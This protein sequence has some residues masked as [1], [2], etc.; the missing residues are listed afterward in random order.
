MNYT[1]CP[2]LLEA[3]ERLRNGEQ[4]M[5]KWIPA[6]PLMA[7]AI[8]P[9][10]VFAALGALASPTF[11]Q[12][13]TDPVLWNLVN[14]SMAELDPSKFPDISQSR[15]NLDQQI[16]NFDRYLESSPSQGPLWK[17]FLKWNDLQKELA[18]PTP[19][20]EALNDLEKRFRQNYAGLE[21]S[22]FVGLRDALSKYVQDSR[23]ARDPN[24][25]MQILKNRLSKLSERMQLPDMERDPKAI[26]DLA[27]LVAYMKQANQSPEFVSS[28]LSRYSQ[29]NIRAIVSDDFLR[30]S[31]ARPVDQANPVSEVILGTTI[32]GQSILCGNVSPV[33]LENPNQA[34]LRLLMNAD[35]ASV[36]KGYNRGVVLNTTGSADV[37]ACETLSLGD[38]GLMALGDTG[39]DAQLSTVIQSIEHRL[40]IVRKIAAKQAAKKKPQADAIG[41]ARM[42]NRIR[43]QFHQ[44]LTEQLSEANRKLS[45]AMESPLISR[46]GIS[47][48]QR[49]SWSNPEQLGLRWKV[50]SGT[51][52]A[53]DMP[54]PFPIDDCG[55]TLQIHESVVG[56]LLDPVLAGRI[57]RSDEIDAYAAQFGDAAK[58]IPRKE[59]DGP[60]AITLNNFQPVETVFDDNLIKFRVTTSRLEREDQ[61]LPNTATVEAA[62]KIVQADGTIQL[63][64]QGDLNV[65]FAGK[66]QQGT[67]GVVLRT[68]LKNK[69]EQLFREKLFD[70]PIRWSDRLPDQFK[71]LQLCAVGIDDG[72]LQLQI[73]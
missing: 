24:T 21:Y 42:E 15:A 33:L 40:K 23:M 46:L 52:L 9:A 39:A 54:C 44:Q 1:I 18:E 26:H 34:T 47:K 2:R 65:E 51:Q 66:V 67:R 16:R 6:G 62:Y 8:F 41:E 38:T 13:T 53:S 7:P 32:I 71:D 25:T 43:T 58:G 20:P 64:R 12:N 4:T 29:P 37:V 59:E 48:P 30:K 22:P 70:S 17:S 68:F 28:I 19:N 3:D 61:A 72:W 60:W 11:G 50:Q 36:N 73:R 63:E 49:N 27:Q 69:F 55:L 5:K 56:N 14:R 35:F 10:L 31:F 57:L 45:E